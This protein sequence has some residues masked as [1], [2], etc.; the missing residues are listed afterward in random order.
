MRRP[1]SGL[2]LLMAA[3]LV[4]CSSGS[5]TRHTPV[6]TSPPVSTSSPTAVPA[7]S[8]TAVP[9]PSPAHVFVVVM[10]NTSYATA[11]AQ[12]AI[13]SLAFTYAIATDYHAVTHPSLPNYLALTAGE[14]FGI[15]DDAYHRL[16]ATGIGSQLDQ[17][18]LPWRAYFEGLHAGCFDSP[19]PYALKHNSFA[20]L[21][22]GCPSQVVDISQ[23]DADLAQPASSAPRL[24]WITPGLC[25]D[26]HDCAPP[27]AA[28]YLS[29]LVQKITASP[30]WQDGGV[31]FI[32]WDEDDGSAS[33][34]V[35]LIVV[36]PG[37][38]GAASARPYDHYSLLATV[39]DLLGVPR[40]G[41]AATAAT[42]DDLVRAPAR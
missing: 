4:A 6:G 31:L 42:I 36:S 38:H 27:V 26:G 20:Y 12:P 18:G 14:T 24:S 17:R 39:E 7:S 28:T 22:G 33:N 41:N 15:S 2:A 9:A 35:P 16:P 37:A 8:P 29:T 25:H 3:L 1:V 11:L 19:A 32:T 34:H 10:E 40:L 23:L 21:G 13:A 5:A 30:A